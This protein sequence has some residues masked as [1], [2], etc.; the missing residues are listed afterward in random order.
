[1]KERV[2]KLMAQANIG[3]R[4]ACEDLISQ[5]RV[6]VNGDVITLGDKADPQKDIIHVDGER[7]NLSQHA[8]VYIALNKPRNVISTSKAHRGDKR[9]TIY[10]L[11][12]VPGHLF[13]IGRLDAD[14]EGLIVLTNDGDMANH[15]T[16]PR[17]RHTKTYRVTV[18]G[19]PTPDALENWQNGIFLDEEG[20]T[21]P[22]V[23]EVL[24]SEGGLSI[25]KV[26]MTEGKKRQIRRVA[27]QLGY[28]VRKLVRTHIGKLSL[29]ALASGT[30]RELTAE[31]VESMKTPDMVLKRSTSDKPRRPYHDRSK[32]PSGSGGGRPPSKANRNIA[33]NKP[34]PRKP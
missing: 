8:H 19:T 22:C 3:S 27:G 18:Y 13:A 11:V 31:E 15:L 25:L 16:H 32:R 29:G 14:S 2:Q 6:R 24:K 20:R 9:K 7:L 4:R 30:W 34:R 21:A 17:Y 23:V 5:G 12:D 26:I 33:R 10:D 28:P 1:M